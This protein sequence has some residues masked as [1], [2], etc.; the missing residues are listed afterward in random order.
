MGA[1]LWKNSKEE[2]EDVSQSDGNTAKLT[3]KMWA[4]PPGF[5]CPTP[6]LLHSAQISLELGKATH[7]ELLG[8]KRVKRKKKKNAMLEHF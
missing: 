1:W 5:S 8:M 3:A 2:S 7:S 4:L 6:T